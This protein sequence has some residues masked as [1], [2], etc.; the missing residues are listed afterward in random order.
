MSND[1]QV[2]TTDFSK[3]TLMPVSS[4]E[5]DSR[6][7]S[8]NVSAPEDDDD[9]ATLEPCTPSD[10]GSEGVQYGPPMTDN[11]MHLFDGEGNY[12]GK[13]DVKFTPIADNA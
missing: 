10:D 4:I 9:I 13:T 3:L 5:N 6:N 12:V 11:N 1:S 2:N 8:S 7:V